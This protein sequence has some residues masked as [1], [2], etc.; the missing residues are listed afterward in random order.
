[1]GK[2]FLSVARKHTR[3]HRTH[4]HFKCRR[5]IFLRTFVHSI[6]V[7]S[8]HVEHA[9]VC[10][11]LCKMFATSVTCANFNHCMDYNFKNGKCEEYALA[12]AAHTAQDICELTDRDR[13][14][15]FDV[16]AYTNGRELLLFHVRWIRW[17]TRAP[18]HQ[19]QRRNICNVVFIHSLVPFVQDGF[20]HSPG[21]EWKS[22]EN[23]MSI[24]GNNDLMIITSYTCLCVGWAAAAFHAK[25]EP[26]SFCGMRGRRGGR[27]L[28]RR[29]RATMKRNFSDGNI[30]RPDRKTRIWWPYGRECVSSKFK[31]FL[32]LMY[33]NER[34]RRHSFPSHS[35]S[36]CIHRRG[37]LALIFDTHGKILSPVKKK[38]KTWKKNKW[39]YL[40]I[41][42][43]SAWPY[44]AVVMVREECM[45]V[46]HVEYRKH[47][48]KQ[49]FPCFVQY[50]AHSSLSFNDT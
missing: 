5:A 24:I 48:V 11:H 46:E 9:C 30:Y 50:F 21:S 25:C 22:K 19:P 23:I 40:F 18:R 39:E 41:N 2:Y 47:I 14:G 26:F 27:R 43:L 37:R 16:F 10:V 45:S 29:M 28:A 6:I 49:H 34:W 7:S 12:L 1:M 36:T 17:V 44:F 8:A 42:T 38:K 20:V 32:I 33:P 31:S 13:A 3:T 15:P 35:R 4:I